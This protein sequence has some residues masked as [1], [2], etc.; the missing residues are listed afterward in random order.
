[1]GFGEFQTPNTDSNPRRTNA[2]VKAF[3]KSYGAVPAR[4]T[5]PPPKPLPKPDLDPIL[6]DFY[7]E[8]GFRVRIRSKRVDGRFG[9]LGPRGR[10]GWNGS[11]AP[12][13]VLRMQSH[14]DVYTGVFGVLLVRVCE[15]YRAIAPITLSVDPT[16][17]A[18]APHTAEA[19]P[20]PTTR[21]LQKT[22]QKPQ[23]PATVLFTKPCF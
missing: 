2:L 9:G 8:R 18:A 15:S 3:R 5:P 23:A 11:V 21:P 6:S 7:L 10:S 16:F 22:Q 20:R 13:K 1:M 14:T 12:R 4:S 17:A 19:P